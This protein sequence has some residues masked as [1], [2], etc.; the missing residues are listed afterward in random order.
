M[1]ERRHIR[2]QLLAFNMGVY[3]DLV[4]QVIH[5]HAFTYPRNLFIKKIVIMMRAVVRGDFPWMHRDNRD[6]IDFQ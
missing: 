5:L 3:G 6:I 4:F 2:N 1:T